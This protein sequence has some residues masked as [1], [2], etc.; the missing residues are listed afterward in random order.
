[1]KNTHIEMPI[2][3]VVLE[4][5]YIEDRLKAANELLYLFGCR[6]LFDNASG[7]H[8]EINP[9]TPQMSL[10][11]ATYLLPIYDTPVRKE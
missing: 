6:L 5:Q 3:R 8:L 10:S 7:F 11:S 2:R 4:T 9:G 1:M